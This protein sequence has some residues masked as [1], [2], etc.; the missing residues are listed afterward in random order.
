MVIT[1]TNSVRH[2]SIPPETLI[3]LVHVINGE[4]IGTSRHLVCLVKDSFLVMNRH[5]VS[6]RHHFLDPMS[7]AICQF[8]T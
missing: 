3:W 6:V 4:E 5:Q 8:I 1:I 7:L 2:I